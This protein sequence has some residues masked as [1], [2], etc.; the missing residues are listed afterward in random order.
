MHFPFDGD[1]AACELRAPRRELVVSGE[2]CHVAR[3]GGAVRRNDAG[4]RASLGGIKISNALAP[5]RS[6]MPR[7]AKP[8]T[9]SSPN[10]CS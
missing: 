3:A 7:G 5:Q 4:V 2:K 8:V 6:A 10:T 1:R 9:I